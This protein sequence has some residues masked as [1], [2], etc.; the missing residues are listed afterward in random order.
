M[1]TDIFESDDVKSVSSLSPN[2]KPE[3]FANHFELGCQTRLGDLF[4]FAWKILFNGHYVLRQRNVLITITHVHSH[5]SARLFFCSVTLLL[6]LPSWFRKL[7]IDRERVLICRHTCFDTF[8]IVQI[9]ELKQLVSGEQS[10]FSATN[11]LHG[12]CS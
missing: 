8:S 10:K 3:I 9:K 1:K 11:S 4:H 6:P 2:N 7:P 5:C 12:A